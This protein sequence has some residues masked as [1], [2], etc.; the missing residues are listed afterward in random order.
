MATRGR[1]GVFEVAQVDDEVATFIR[2]GAHHRE[3]TDCLRKKGTRSMAQDGLE[4]AVTGVT[5]MEELRRV[6]TFGQGI[7]LMRRRMDPLSLEIAEISRSDS[8]P[9]F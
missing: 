9:T 4:K 5:C 7:E 2:S 8:D 1:T 3:L 6:C